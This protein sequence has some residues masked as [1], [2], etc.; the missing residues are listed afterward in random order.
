MIPGTNLSFGG[1]AALS[2]DVGGSGTLQQ[3]PLNYRGSADSVQT[4]DGMRLN[5]LE[6]NGAYSGVYWNDGSFQEIS[7]VT[8][9]DSAEMPSAG[10]RI[11]M[12]PR[13]GGNTFRGT[14][15]ANF[16]GEGW[17]SNNL[18]DN[19]QG[20]LTYNASNRLRNVSRLQ[21]IWDF[22]P[23]VGGPIVR[24][25]AWFTLTF[26]HWG[27]QKTVADTYFDADPSAHRYGR[28]DQTRH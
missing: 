20:D 9:A 1:G 17:D 10:I 15:F 12:A 7:Y 27:V 28:T 14:V 18:A 19:L 2:R 16:T 8:G 4:V 25:K 26:R 13:D 3:S 21:N 11:N 5:N 22:N 6:A 23:S 24:D